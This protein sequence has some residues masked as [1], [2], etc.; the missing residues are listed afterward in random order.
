MQ[1]LG[2]IGVGFVVTVQLLI[3][4]PAFDRYW[5]CNGDAMRQFSSYS[6]ISGKPVIQYGGK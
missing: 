2:I 5:R 3:R 4:F 1:L 6:H